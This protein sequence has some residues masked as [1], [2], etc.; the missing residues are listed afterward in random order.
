MEFDA[1]EKLPDHHQI[2]IFI[3]NRGL[4][5][6]ITNHKPTNHYLCFIPDKNR[7]KT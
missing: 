2:Y 6:L 5:F 4:S 1:F 7:A 3:K